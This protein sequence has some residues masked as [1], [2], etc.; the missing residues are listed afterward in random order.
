MNY[1]HHHLGLSAH[2]Q[3]GSIVY[4][5]CS[6]SLAVQARALNVLLGWVGEIVVQNV[7]SRLFFLLPFLFIPVL[8]HMCTLFMRALISSL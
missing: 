2:L 4:F 8:G 7:F 3:T 1:P 6:A 5:G